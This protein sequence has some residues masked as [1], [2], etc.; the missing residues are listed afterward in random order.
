MNSRLQPYPAHKVST[1]HLSTSSS[2]RTSPF[3]VYPDRVGVPPRYPFPRSPFASPLHDPSFQQLPTIKLNYPTRI[4]HPERSEGSLRKRWPLA[5]LCFQWV[6]TVKFSNNFV[7]ITIRIAGG[8]YTPR[9]FVQHPLQICTFIFQLLA[10]CPS[11]NPFRFMV[12]H[13]CRGVVGG[14]PN[15]CA[16]K[17]D[18]ALGGRRYRKT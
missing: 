13:R 8:G 5:V 18:A 14:T 10:R 12:L 11:H 6:T 4:V 3:G 17:G 15:F 9:S 1:T 7:L 2:L 16:R